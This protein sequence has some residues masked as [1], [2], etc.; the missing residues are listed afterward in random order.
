MVLYCSAESAHVLL[1]YRSKDIVIKSLAHRLSEAHIYLDSPQKHAA[2]I[3]VVS[4]DTNTFLKKKVL[5]LYNKSQREYAE[6]HVMQESFAR[7]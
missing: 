6:D 4:P 5:L 7:M 1:S 2:L 3:K